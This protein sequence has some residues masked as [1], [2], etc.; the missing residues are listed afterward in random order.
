MPILKRQVIS[1]SNIASFFIAITHNS[2]LNLKHINFLLWIKAYHKS[3]NFE[4]FK[5]FGENLPN[6]SCYFPNNKSVFPQFLHH[7]LLVCT[8]LP[9]T[10]YTLVINSQWKCNFLI[11]LSARVKICQI[12]HVSFEATCQFLFIFLI[13]RQCHYSVIIPLKIFSTCIFYF[14]QKDFIKVPILTLSSVLVKICQIPHLICKP[15]DSFSSNFAWLF[16]IIKDN[17]SVFF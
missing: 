15:Q 10:W 16:S 6:S 14:G 13:I 11:L 4:T 17:F 3:P 9:Q 12:P 2:P 7:S 8:F 1:F 5:C